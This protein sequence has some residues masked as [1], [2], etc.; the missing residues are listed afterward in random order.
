MR[1]ES[2]MLDAFASWLAPHTTLVSYNGRCYDAPLLATRFRLSRKPPP[3]A[4]LRHLDLLFPTRRRY[5]GRW[6]NCR[7]AT[8]E[9]QVLGVV[10]E[11]DLPGSEAPRAWL[12]W[13]RGGDARDFRRVLAHNDQDV[14]S[15]VRLLLHLAENPA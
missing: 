6:E 1:G 4:D 12:D 3:H 11:D 14:R 10:R 15:L 7:L 2:A 5:R 13:L 8:I 9:R